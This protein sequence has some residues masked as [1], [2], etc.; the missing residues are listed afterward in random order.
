[1]GTV[2]RAELRGPEGFRKELALKVIR[3]DLAAED[4]DLREAIVREARY[5]AM[6][7]HGNVVDVYDFGVEE[8]RPWI[9]MELILGVGL[10]RLIQ[11]AQL[12]PTVA[13]DLAAQIS[14]GLSHTHELCEAGIPLGLVH[15][16]LKPANVLVTRDGRAKISDFGLVMPTARMERMRPEEAQGTPAYMSPEQCRGEPLDRRSDLFA[17][18]LLTWELVTGRRY[19][20]GAHVLGTMMAILE[21][22]AEL[23]QRLALVDEGVPG[24]A[25]VLRRFLRGDPGLRFS[26]A[27]QAGAALRAI[28]RSLPPGP[29]ARAWMSRGVAPDPEIVR[30]VESQPTLAPPVLSAGV[31]APLAP[32][33]ATATQGE[34]RPPTNLLPEADA[35]VGR[36]GLLASVAGALSEEVGIH[37]LVGAAGTG[38]TRLARRVGLEVRDRFPGGVW[39]VDLSAVRTAEGLDP[40]VAAALGLA[41]AGKD[42]QGQIA[43]A[44]AARG[45]TLLILDN[46]EQVVDAAASFVR[47]LRDAV[48]GV[49]FLVTTR[50]ALRLRDE[51]LHPIEPMAVPLGGERGEE[52]L[53]IDAVALF[54]DRA[55][56]ADPAFQLDATNTDAVAQV[57][58]RLDGIPLAIELAAARVRVLSVP[59]LLG[60][61]SHRFALLTSA[62]RDTVARQATLRAAIDWSWR[63]LPP[64]EQAA[65]AQCSVFSGTFSIDAVD[66]IFDLSPWTEAPWALDVLQSLVDKSVV[67]SVASVDGERRFALLESIAEFAAARLA[68]P[69]GIRRPDGGTASGPQSVA[70][71]AE[72]HAAFFSAWGHDGVLAPTTGGLPDRQFLRLRAELGNLTAAVERAIH[73]GDTETASL[74]LLAALV[75]IDR[76]GPFR[77]GVDLAR[78]VLG[79][80]GLDE[81]RRMLILLVAGPM[82]RRIGQVEEATRMLE[83]ALDLAQRL[84]DRPREAMAL[85]ALGMQRELVG[86][87]EEALTLVGESLE[88][89]RRLRDPRLE[90]SALATRGTILSEH[91]RLSEAL[92][93]YQEALAVSQGLGDGPEDA[94]W[95]QNYGCVHTELG[96][97]DEAITLFERALAAAVRHQDRRAE[98][99]VLLNMGVAA[100]NLGRTENARR[101]YERSLRLNQEV[102]DGHLEGIARLNLAEVLAHA[103][104]LD[105]S[106]T[107]L[108]GALLLPGE[109][110]D[111]L[112]AMVQLEL[113]QI[114]RLQGR[115]DAAQALARQALAA[116]EK[117]GRPRMAAHARLRL[118]LIVLESGGLDAAE[119]DVR[120]AQGAYEAVGD[121]RGVGAARSALAEVLMERGEFVGA[122]N[123]ATEAIVILDALGDARQTALARARRAMACLTLGQ[124]ADAGASWRAAEAEAR[125]LGIGEQSELGLALARFPGGLG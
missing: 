22:E 95:L 53:A 33:P 105:E 101:H 16:D 93:A 32:A 20:V 4:A 23:D 61:L 13:L 112:L 39:F 100:F 80:E 44:L 25:G 34:G 54:V 60:R 76:R 106:R 21:V 2:W 27:S 92:A 81:R 11:E 125:R 87:T 24:L 108:R 49:M 88:L 74:S 38:K 30:L 113:A 69:G 31:T 19:F 57:V 1:M 46:V 67:R 42:P 96:R 118:G 123:A 121:R 114:E 5:G 104:E 71:A 70:Q 17:L 82:G 91:G 115:L 10:D 18:G 28:L 117:A 6:L 97:S 59:A 85:R 83:L 109:T 52:L 41:A 72:R 107:V 29:D 84:G 56:A 58:A 124:R 103:G 37:A 110:G 9:A 120:R 8:G 51:V 3:E 65:L 45:R 78:R 7:H 68:E 47:G 12:P 111:R 90:A 43:T 99:G 116:F 62:R 102:G 36:G 15:R 98:V 35:F 79:M 89:G 64:W 73:R 63:L 48:P 14:D 26:A 75:V 119:L 86:Q 94:A 55:R 77:L 122:R 66:A 40:A 50:T